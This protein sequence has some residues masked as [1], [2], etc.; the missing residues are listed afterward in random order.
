VLSKP[1]PLFHPGRNR[2]RPQAFESLGVPPQFPTP[3]LPPQFPTPR[4]PLPA[5]PQQRV[6]AAWILGIPLRWMQKS[7]YAGASPERRA[8]ASS[9]LARMPANGSR[10]SSILTNGSLLLIVFFLQPPRT[11]AFSSLQ[12]SYLP[13][14]F[15]M[16]P[17]TLARIVPM[18]VFCLVKVAASTRYA[19]L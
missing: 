5:P 18:A 16:A 10:S 11:L 2:F 17:S 3:P 15:A 4:L 14:H 12:T 8:R 13:E 7:I 9:I 6:R 1:G 19:L